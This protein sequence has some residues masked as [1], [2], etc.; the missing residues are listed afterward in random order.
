MKNNSDSYF[1]I[2]LAISLVAHILFFGGIYYYQ[3][4]Q[5]SIK[6]TVKAPLTMSINVFTPAPKQEMIQPKPKPKPPTPKPKPLK[7]KPPKPMKP[8]L[9]PKPSQVPVPVPIEEVVE[10]V[11]E[12]V[13]EEVVEQVAQV[14]QTSSMSREEDEYSRTKALIN[15]A[16]NNYKIFPY[17]AKSRNMEGFADIEITV[18]KNGRIVD[19]KSINDRANRIFVN[20]AIETFRKAQKDFPKPSRTMTFQYKI[21]YT[22]EKM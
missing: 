16:F 3:K 2:A 18:D 15:A 6:S 7:P 1:S 20:D 19:I 13:V 14:G 8:E 10:E 5:K 12:E 11:K 4:Q 9:L 21:S 17:R 22:I